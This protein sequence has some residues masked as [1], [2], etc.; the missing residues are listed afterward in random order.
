[1]VRKFFE[2]KVLWKKGEKA[3]NQVDI[4]SKLVEGYVV[5]FYQE[6]NEGS[7]SFKIEMATDA[8]SCKYFWENYDKIMKQVE[9]EARGRQ[10]CHFNL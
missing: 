8:L 3:R 6:G 9:E 2:K 4:Y 5:A 7:E 1:M 10:V